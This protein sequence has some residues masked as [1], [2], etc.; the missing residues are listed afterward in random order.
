[1]LTVKKRNA[2]L[3]NTLVVN[4]MRI[5]SIIFDFNKLATN[6]M[7]SQILDRMKYIVHYE[8]ISIYNQK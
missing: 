8:Y 3:G 6:R 2:R 5:G 7:L 1:M 4:I